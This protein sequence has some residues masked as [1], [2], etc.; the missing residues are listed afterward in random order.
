MY[1]KVPVA[2][3][4]RRFELGKLKIIVK[5][6][7]DKADAALK[8]A[9]EKA[10]VDSADADSTTSLPLVHVPM[11]NGSPRDPL[12]VG[13]TADG[14]SPRR[15]DDVQVDDEAHAAQVAATQS[16]DKSTPSA[17]AAIASAAQQRRVKGQ[18]QTPTVVPPVMPSVK[19]EPTHSEESFR[20]AIEQS[21]AQEVPVDETE[22]PAEPTEVPDE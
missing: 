18:K 3:R 14:L 4:V 9:E 12:E 7:Q 17:S 13:S 19:E 20:S 10:E 8:D 5:E 11:M 21:E 16:A 15:L 22:V 1:L 2:Y 6:L